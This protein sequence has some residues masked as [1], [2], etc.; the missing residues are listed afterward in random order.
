MTLFLDGPAQTP[1]RRAE[2]IRS[3]PQAGAA[4]KTT[5]P[6]PPAQKELDMS[7]A[8]PTK[9]RIFA[10]LRRAFPDAATRAALL[11]AHGGSDTAL[12]VY[13]NKLVRD[14]LVERADDG[15]RLL[16]EAAEDEREDEDLEDE[17]D[18][19]KQLGAEE[20]LEDGDGDAGQPASEEEPPAEL[21][22]AGDGD[23]APAGETPR[24]EHGALEPD[25]ARPGRRVAA[26]LADEAASRLDEAQR[27]IGLA[28]SQIMLGRSA[29]RR[30]PVAMGGEV[31]ERL[32]TAALSL[33]NGAGELRVAT[34]RFLQTARG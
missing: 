29:M 24:V 34:I 23:G 1:M 26:D 5:T 32:S 13:M 27:L 4:A 21:A 10:V 2:D 30:I 33:N 31:G 17:R 18:D 15:W 3:A 25:P 28:L 8:T 11:G 19:D 16:G 6:A 12:R 22:P 9:D 14:N 20:D 7:K